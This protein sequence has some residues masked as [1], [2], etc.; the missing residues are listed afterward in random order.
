VRLKVIT[1]QEVGFSKLQSNRTLSLCNMP[2]EI[3]K[4]KKEHLD[5]YGLPESTLVQESLVFHIQ[6][7][8][9][10]LQAKILSEIAISDQPTFK[11]VVETAIS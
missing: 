3:E 6:S 4:I 10:H 5:P 11:K 1:E 2:S 8:L 9:M 7:L